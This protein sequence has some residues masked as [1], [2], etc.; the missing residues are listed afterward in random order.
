MKL[1]EEFRKQVNRLGVENIRQAWFTSF[2]LSPHFIETYILQVLANQNQRMSSLADYEAMQTKLLDQDIDIRFFS[3]NAAIDIS[4]PKRTSFPVHLLNPGELGAQFE[5]GVFHPK[6]I[7]LRAQD[8]TAIVGAGSA[9][10]SLSGWGRN[11]EVFIFK[12]IEDV[13]N[14]TRVHAF[15][16]SLFQAAKLD[17]PD[18]KINPG[19]AGKEEKAP[20]WKF[21]SSLNN[22]RLFDHLKDGAGD[23]LHV[24]S[25]YFSEDLV[26]LKTN[27]IDAQ[28]ERSVKVSI[29]PDVVDNNGSKQ[30]RISGSSEYR[31]KLLSRPDI[32]FHK[33]CWPADSEVY[34]T[35]AKLWQFGNRMA[36]GSW[37]CTQAG[38][39]VHLHSPGHGR[40]CNIEAG[41]LCN[42]ISLE[43]FVTLPLQLDNYWMPEEQLQKEQEDLPW[44]AGRLPFSLEV[45][46]NWDA[47]THYLLVLEGSVGSDTWRI[48]LPGVDETIVLSQTEQ[49]VPLKRE[50]LS[51]LM[52][53]RFYTITGQESGIK[54]SGI[55]I[56][57]GVNNRPAYVFESFTD[58][59]DA[60]NS[61]APEKK[62]DMHIPSILN[63]FTTT[64]EGLEEVGG[65]DLEKIELELPD[66][67]RTFRAFKNMKERFSC[68]TGEGEKSRNPSDSRRKQE[69]FRLIQK[70]PGSLSE[71][72]DKVG[73]VLQN[74]KY[75]PVFRWI[76]KMEYQELY[77]LAQKEALPFHIEVDWPALSLAHVEVPVRIENK[78][79]LGLVRNLAGYSEVIP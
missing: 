63:S 65:G 56:E 61:S 58:L 55:V 51:V 12:R 46:F 5:Q 13:E 17:F 73:E 66:Y 39:N 74:D 1:L 38:T 48:N 78:E 70:D 69:L 67:F 41:L 29:Y 72:C 59:I 79:L 10:L 25:P 54:I 42:D 24:C 26:Q 40:L 45:C 34:M 11:R 47:P 7:F 30:V 32:D 49:R 27:Y 19:E 16:R 71:L 60:W 44:N 77:T 14:S 4:E 37:N 2:N 22:D 76:I 62:K 18:L 43:N 52:K 31:E 64:G 8:G 21:L 36:V 28:L 23:I 33:V 3:D 50:K 68:E 75:T 20:N 35:H 6:V 53:K 57:T 15:F 9:N